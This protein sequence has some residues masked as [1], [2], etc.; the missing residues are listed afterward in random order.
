LWDHFGNGELMAINFKKDSALIGNK[1]LEN[2]QN[3]SKIWQKSFTEK[4]LGNEN[5]ANSFLSCDKKK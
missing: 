5:V 2:S 1:S 3:N 4:T